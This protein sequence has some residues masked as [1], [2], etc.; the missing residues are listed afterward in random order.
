MKKFPK[1]A[2]R[3][4]KGVI[5]DVYQWRQKMFDNTYEI[6][7]GLERADTVEV[8]GV[9]KDKKIII[10]QQKQPGTSWFMSL[11]GGRMEKGESPV[12]AAKREFLEETGYKVSKIKLFKK[13][14]PLPKWDWSIY[15]YIARD[16][17][18]VSESTPDS[19]EKLKT[20]IITFNQ[21]LKLSDNP[22]CKSG[23]IVNYLLRGRLNKN[24][25][26]KFK[27]L[28]FK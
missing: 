26:N 24:M 6:F 2:K 18:K 14:D 12:D 28:L 11:P 10:Q 16:V 3:V 23:E 17:E 4:F 1:K 15:I 19:G 27:K 21:F 9:T 20:S 5:F 8:I 13:I 25:M 7:E 22:N